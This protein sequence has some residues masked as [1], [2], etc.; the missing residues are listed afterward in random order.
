MSPSSLSERRHP[1]ALGWEA[2][3]ANLVPALIIQALM[4]TVF[5]AYYL[6]PTFAEG[7]NRVA[8]YKKAYGLLFVIPASILA[9]S[10]LPEIFLVLFFQRGR[11]RWENCRSILFTA[12]IWALDGVA[13][14]LLY[15]G[16]AAWLGDT[17]SL[18]IV[19]AKLCIDQFVYNVFFAAPYAVLA[20]QWKNGGYSIGVLRRNLT[21]LDFRDKLVPT[22][23]T[24]WAVWIPV[25]AI[26]YS[27][28]LALQF[29]LASL[30][31]T[32]W[33]LLLTYM[34]N[35]FAG[36]SGRPAAAKRMEMSPKLA[37]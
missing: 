25:M 24:T 29:P 11:V 18:P 31:L 7:L 1:L 9:A 2:V 4:F 27:L 23:F 3:R 34:T 35:R 30:A 13:I 19:F 26:I 32:F 20:Y 36:K 33:V 22:L 10:I 28:P 16:L 15:R 12:P 37:Q 21:A 14:D 6:S 17:A 8:D 5:A